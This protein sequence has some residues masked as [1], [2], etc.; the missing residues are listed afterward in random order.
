MKV[1]IWTLLLLMPIV[2]M[3][4]SDSTCPS[5]IAGD[6][7][8]DVGPSHDPQ[9]ATVYNCAKP[10]A[11]GVQVF[12][13]DNVRDTSRGNKI[14]DCHSYIPSGSNNTYNENV[15]TAER[16]VNTCKACMW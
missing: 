1:L 9:V 4:D 7:I 14:V 16:T 10:D 12:C 2:S 15:V 5:Q 8:Q 6:N 11:S 13:Y 3:A